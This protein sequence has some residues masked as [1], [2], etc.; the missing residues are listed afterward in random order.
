MFFIFQNFLVIYATLNLFNQ[1]IICD[2]SFNEKNYYHLS[3]H[4]LGKLS[5]GDINKSSLR[6][7]DHLITIKGDSSPIFGNS[8]SIN[9]YYIDLYVGNPPQ[10]QS[11]IIDTGSHLTSVPCLPH[12]EKCGKHLNEYYDMRLSNESKLV[13]C[14]D[15]TCTNM[16][17]GTCGT[18][19]QCQFFIVSSF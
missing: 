4:K 9:Y 11:L 15:D 3:T 1:F 14:K 16:W 8:T 5:V 18:N 17:G 7:L 12:C 6:N 10:K 13:N 19:N 2:K